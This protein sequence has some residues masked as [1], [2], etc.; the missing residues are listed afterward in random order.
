M[1][2]EA[3]L[4]LGVDIASLYPKTAADMLEAAGY[5]PHVANV[6]AEH[7]EQKRVQTIQAVRAE[8]ARAVSGGAG[9]VGL[10][11]SLRKGGI[12]TSTPGA[13]AFHEAGESSLIQRERLRA[14]KAK[15]KQRQDMEQLVM[16]EARMVKM[17][18]AAAASDRA[19]YEAE[20]Q[21]KRDAIVA[22][23]KALEVRTAPPAVRAQRLREA[24]SFAR[25][26]ARPA[27]A[28][29]Q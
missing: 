19:R 8:R 26:G 27:Q 1:Q 2:I 22:K 9:E 10:S 4:S 3:C 28:R 11:A 20:Q 17:A 18:E 29:T 24:C 25:A 5:K 14:E 23:K 12:R 21:R 16:N 6:L 7:Y 13:S 15:E